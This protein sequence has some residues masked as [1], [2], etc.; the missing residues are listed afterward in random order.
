MKRT[1]EIK[2]RMSREE[3]DRLNTLV[4]VTGLSREEYARRLF[5]GATVKENPPADYGEI[6]RELRCIGRNVD[7]ILVKARSL[8][9]IDSVLCQD[10]ANSIFQM[11]KMFR[12]TFSK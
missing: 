8:G 3:F 4:H 7:Q 6:L 11:E 9:F 12:K 1:K 2:V 5:L 10:V